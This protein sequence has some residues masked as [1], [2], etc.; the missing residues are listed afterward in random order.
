VVE[1]EDRPILASRLGHVLRREQSVNIKPSDLVDL[2]GPPQHAPG[3][4]DW[5]AATSTFD[6]AFPS[7]YRLLVETYPP[8][9]VG[10]FIKVLHPAAE[11]DHGNLIASAPQAMD[12]LRW[13]KRRG[14]VRL[15]YEVHPDAP[16]LL[17]W[18][19]TLNGDY[20]LWLTDG[21]PDNWSVVVTDLA[22]CWKFDGGLFEFLFGV[23][24]RKVRC[25]IFPDDFPTGQ[26][27]YQEPCP[28]AVEPCGAR[29]D[30][31]LQ[32]P[33]LNIQDQPTFYSHESTLTTDR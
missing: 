3:Q 26:E 24:S 14:N 11:A 18:G 9:V 7:D 31:S 27:H 13:L 22:F 28:G 15:P 32:H 17:P 19:A 16:G 20:C 25:P 2:L 29:V 23:L 30:D 6:T 4:I 8:L 10:G 1:D 33:P 12:A 5:E 21:E